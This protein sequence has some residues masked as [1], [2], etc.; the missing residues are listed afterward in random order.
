MA[1]NSRD[2]SHWTLR[3]D[4]PRTYVAGNFMR[5]RAQVAEDMRTMVTRCPYRFR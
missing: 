4:R 5:V 2:D 1:S 3:R